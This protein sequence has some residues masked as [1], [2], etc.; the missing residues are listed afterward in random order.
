LKDN[1]QYLLILRKS[2]I[3]SAVGSQ[4]QGAKTAKEMS[5]LQQQCICTLAVLRVSTAYK[6]I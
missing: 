2:I 3:K 1:L 5:D 4:S 6:T